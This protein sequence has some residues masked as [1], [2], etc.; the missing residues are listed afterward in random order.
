MKE[1]T[2]NDL[3]NICKEEQIKGNGNKKILISSDD[4]GN[5]FHVLFFGFSNARELLCGTCPPIHPCS[6]DEIDDYIVL[7]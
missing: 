4:E 1:Y 6:E 5:E 2:V 7:G 3:F